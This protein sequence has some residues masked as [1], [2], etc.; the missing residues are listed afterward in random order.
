MDENFE[1]AWANYCKLCKLSARDFFV[2][3]LP[4][5]GLEVPYNDGCVKHVVE[6]LEAEIL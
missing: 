2:N 1:N 4:Q 5:A 6:K 3:I